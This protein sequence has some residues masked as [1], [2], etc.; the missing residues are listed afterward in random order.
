MVRRAGDRIALVPRPKPLPPRA[1]IDAVRFRLPDPP[2]R[3]PIADE[4]LRAFPDRRSEIL[5]RLAA[6][7]VV[8][9]NGEPVG[10][11]APVVKGVDVWIH[12]EPAEEPEVPGRLDIVHADQDLVVVDK[13]HFLATTPRAGH[14]RETV[15]VRGRVA[16]G[17]D[18][19]VPAHRLD[20][21]TAG[22]V[23]MAVHPRVRAAL[24]TQFQHRGV[25][26]KYLAVTSL[27]EGSPAG[28]VRE[29][30]IE[31]THGILQGAEVR[32]EPN[33]RTRGRLLGATRGDDGKRLGLWQLSPETGQTHQLRIHLA[34]L[35]M[36]ILDD[37]L[38]PNVRTLGREDF[39]RPLQLLAAGLEFEHP[40]G[41]CGGG[42]DRGFDTG[43]VRF[44]SRRRLARWPE[45]KEWPG[46][47]EIWED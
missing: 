39:S 19:L 31:K 41:D 28:F 4:L 2:G 25:T 3:G 6:G 18:S 14:I 38:Y 23:A 22:L 8:D 12:L 16:T 15:L 5:E 24:S 43:R 37:D 13:P 35:G 1:G 40:A 47:G 26:K 42:K 30:R 46:E 11:Y 33:A 44:T 34:A 45:G 32:G 29:S 17:H 10:E 7:G 27:P 9:R 36:P 21:G 20:R